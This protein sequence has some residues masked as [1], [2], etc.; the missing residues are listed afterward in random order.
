MVSEPG[1][2]TL[3]S[4]VSLYSTLFIAI[5][6]RQVIRDSST[7]Y[8]LP[9]TTSPSDPRCPSAVFSDFVCETRTPSLPLTHAHAGTYS[10]CTY[11]QKSKW[12]DG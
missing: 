6:F 11:G 9:S 3:Y 1:R 12:S 10:R 5:P 4:L 8:H 2:K 7:L